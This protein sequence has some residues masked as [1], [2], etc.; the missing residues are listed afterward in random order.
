MFWLLLGY[1]IAFLFGATFM[2]FLFFAGCGA[3]GFNRFSVVSAS[4]CWNDW[5]RLIDN[6]DVLAYPW[7]ALWLTVGGAIVLGLC[8]LTNLALASGHTNRCKL[9]TAHPSEIENGAKAGIAK[10]SRLG[11]EDRARLFRRRLPSASGPSTSSH[12][13]AQSGAVE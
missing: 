10:S 4:A 11:T 9:A 7:A 6:L 1:N 3:N 8:A 5:Q 13:H 12:R 2:Q